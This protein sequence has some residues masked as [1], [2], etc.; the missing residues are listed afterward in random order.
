[1]VDT[2]AGM[3]VE[4]TELTTAASAAMVKLLV[5]E[6]WQAT[7]DGVVAL[8]RKVRPD[9]ADRVGLDLDENRAQLLEAADGG[10]T[11]AVEAA[12]GDEW[13]GRLATLVTVEPSL[14]A[15]LRQ[16]LDSQLTPALEQVTSNSAGSVRLSAT[17]TEHSTVIQAGNSVSITGSLNR[18]HD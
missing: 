2:V 7:R 9:T 18:R 1:M 11:A 10:D 5:T 16:L 3:N 8:W 4:L 17:A 14:V 15:D 12:L 13:R 6:A